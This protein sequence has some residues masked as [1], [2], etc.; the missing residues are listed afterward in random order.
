MTSKH[1]EIEADVVADNVRILSKRQELSE[2]SPR[3]VAILP[4]E[5]I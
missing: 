5:V 3:I 1:R 2:N 4:K